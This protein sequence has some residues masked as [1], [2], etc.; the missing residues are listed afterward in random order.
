MKKEHF[1]TQFN[2]C[3]SST[4]FKEPRCTIFSAMILLIQKHPSR[5]FLQKKCSENTLQIYRRTPMPKCDFNKVAKQL[6]WNHTLA[7]VLS[8]NVSRT[9][10]YM[11]TSEGLLP[12]ILF[13]TSRCLKSLFNVFCLWISAVVF[14]KMHYTFLYC[15]HLFI[16]IPPP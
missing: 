8:C 12:L 6:Y 7:L 3:N 5:E 14:W 16:C 9:L 2:N 10:F 13:I 15:V 4:T 1:Q 11:N